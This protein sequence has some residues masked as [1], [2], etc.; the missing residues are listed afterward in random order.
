VLA[1]PST[2]SNAGA[3]SFRALVAADITAI[4]TA[5]DTSN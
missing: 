1:G 2:G 5:S 3:P 4:T